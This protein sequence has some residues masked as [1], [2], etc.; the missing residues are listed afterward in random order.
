[1][2]SLGDGRDDMT[3]VLRGLGLDVTE[4]RGLGDVPPRLRVSW[5]DRN[6]DVTV[7]RASQVTGAR[8]K[9]LVAGLGKGMH[10]VVADRITADARA[11]LNDAGWSWLDRRGHVHLRGPGLL[12]DTAVASSSAPAPRWKPTIRG[13]AGLAVA[14]WLCAHPGEGLSPTGQ[15]ADLGFAPSTI[16]TA[17][18]ALTEA[19]LVDEERKAVLPELFWELAS[20]WRPEWT[21]LASRPDPGDLPDAERGT[22]WALTGDFVAAQSG[23]PLVSGGDGPLELFVPGPVSVTV[24]ARRYGVAPPGTGPAAVAVA[25]VGQVFADQHRS[26]LAGW[27]TAPR[28]A[29]ALG[30]ATDP[31]R[32]REVLQDWPG[33][34]HVWL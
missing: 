15:R 3:V 18:A 19:G 32:G 16:S 28:L 14:Y 4:P 31:A 25:P 29:V 2:T 10:V 12:V 7:T 5:D 11:L 30:L 27:R 24:A 34:G 23:A 33:E 17:M 1:M 21:W 20:A 8:A 22:T 13:R 6:A 26:T 9:E